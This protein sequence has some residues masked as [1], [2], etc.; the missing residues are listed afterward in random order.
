MGILPIVAIG[1]FA[2][3]KLKKNSTEVT[4]STTSSTE[5]SN[6]LK[7]IARAQ[8]LKNKMIEAQAKAGK[9]NY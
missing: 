5:D 7:A 3:S 9:R 2:L 8:L 1:V 4:E 6:R